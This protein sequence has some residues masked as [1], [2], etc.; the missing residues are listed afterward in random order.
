MPSTN[1]KTDNLV[2]VLQMLGS[3][4]MRS[5]KVFV[6]SRP[7]SRS[8]KASLS[9]YPSISLEDLRLDRDLQNYVA[10]E[11]G[12]QRKKPETP[13]HGQPDRRAEY[14]ENLSES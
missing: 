4:P 9:K 13:H 2:P 7:S 14:P 6:T 5:I 3:Y 10:A 11:I 1:A 8:L 12:A